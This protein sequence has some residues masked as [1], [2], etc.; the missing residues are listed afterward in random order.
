MSE[1]DP[2]PRQLGAI[3]FA[4]V[5]GYTKLMQ[6]GEEQT[7]RSI[8]Q[9]KQIFTQ[10]C[11]TYAGRVLEVRGDGF[12]IFFDSVVNSV[13]FAVEVQT[14]S[15]RQT[16]Q[17][18]QGNIKFRIG[19][20]TGDVIT[21]DGSIFGDSVNI[22]ARIESL[23][24]PG[25]VCVSQEVYDYV[26]YK[27]R[28]GYE[29]IGTRQLK[30]VH[31]PIVVFRV[32]NELSGVS[33]LA[34]SR[35]S[36]PV[37]HGESGLLKSLVVVPFKDLP[38]DHASGSLSTGI[39]EDITNLLSRSP[40]L[41]VISRGSTCRCDPEIE[42]VQQFGNRL[43][44]EY[45]VDGDFI[46][47]D[48]SIRITV[49]LIDVVFGE[50]RWTEC[51]DRDLNDFFVILAQMVAAIT[52]VLDAPV[53]ETQLQRQCSD[54]SP[55]FQI[56][57]LILRA[58]QQFYRY[59]RSTNLESRDLYT[60]ALESSPDCGRALTGIARTLNLDY[61]YR[62]ADDL[63]STLDSSAQYVRRASAAGDNDAMAL[64]QVGFVHL[65]RKEHERAIESYQAALNLNPQDADV[66]ADIANALLYTGRA[67]DSIK[68]I[69]SAMRHNPFYP[70]EYLI[71]LG[72]A[73]Y[74]VGRYDDAII[75][76][77]GVYNPATACQLLAASYARANQISK[78][79]FFADMMFE[80]DPGF[81]LENQYSNTPYRST[82]QVDH[83]V[84]GLQL[85]G[86]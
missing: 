50:V 22:A 28:Y 10:L 24:S 79:H 45:V 62:W 73:Y 19:I 81:S 34:A 21:D 49:Q 16:E 70:D 11:E 86:F 52:N 3:L 35:E 2:I 68:Q 65:Y 40:D 9:Y 84:K 76:G 44:V 72:R 38:M 20:N 41:F 42:P 13:Q 1:D 6:E 36:P 4:D 77:S 51:Y 43:G 80:L 39:A 30:N 57:K 74:Q 48:S 83:I 66:I 55:D 15:I 14:N 5:V 26:R 46:V 63:R 53:D 78:A 71:R 59:T 60:T 18:A 58:Q 25:G 33:M 82:D 17:T 64:S 8:K 27:L 23:A 37:L 47:L 56:Y 31:K 32:R 61:F 29:C 69:K 75:A 7:H 12:L 85:A 67:E 54:L